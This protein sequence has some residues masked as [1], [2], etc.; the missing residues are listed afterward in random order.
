MKILSLFLLAFCLPLIAAELISCGKG[1]K[2]VP[3]RDGESDS[4]E[5]CQPLHYQNKEN[6]RETS[7]RS[8]SPFDHFDSRLVIEDKCTPSDY[9]IVRCV[10]EYF[11]NKGRCHKCTNC[12][13]EGKAQ[14][15]PCQVNKDT[16]CC[17]EK[18]MVMRGGKC[19]FDPLYCGPDEYL[20]PKEL[21]DREQCRPCSVKSINPE[22]HRKISCGMFLPLETPQVNNGLDTI[23]KQVFFPGFITCLEF[24]MTFRI[25][26]T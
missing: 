1:E 5:P 13:M 11:L 18:G 8:C 3:G 17:P 14:Q 7:C 4:C 15:E 16:L 6:H 19:Q 26:F 9:K 12:S 10:K 21:S 20:V 25:S 2:L 23:R 24:F 22:R